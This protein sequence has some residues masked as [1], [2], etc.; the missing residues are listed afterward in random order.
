MK[1]FKNS[2]AFT[3]LEGALLIGLAAALLF[4]VAGIQIQTALAD[5][6]L[7]YTSAVKALRDL[8]AVNRFVQ[9]GVDV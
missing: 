2:A 7:L 4:A 9:V 1:K 3:K 5:N 6:C 8:H